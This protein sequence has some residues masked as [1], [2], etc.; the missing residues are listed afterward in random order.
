MLNSLKQVFLMILLSYT[1]GYAQKDFNGTITY[2]FSVVGPDA[3]AVK[4][5]MPK[6]QTFSVL[7]NKAKMTS[8][9]KSD[10]T[11][12]LMIFDLQTDK[13]Y[14]VML[15][16][17]IIQEIPAPAEQDI[18]QL[19]TERTTEKLSV[20]GYSC[21][22]YTITDQTM[23]EAKI[24]VWATEDFK[25]PNQTAKNS[26]LAQYRDIKGIPLKQQFTEGNLTFTIEATKVDLTKPK[27]ETM[28]LPKDF[29]IVPFE[30]HDDHGDHD[31]DHG[32]H[33]GHHHD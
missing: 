16:E 27:A 6:A 28:E 15:Q 12:D 9:D 29:K 23:P 17:K 18:S 14:S 19:K 4:D 20:L 22:K 11:L 30:Q 24:Y 8:I 25:I 32:S 5:Q 1:L 13:K 26:P 21:V 33:D 31:H 2:S 7:A 3:A 10:Q